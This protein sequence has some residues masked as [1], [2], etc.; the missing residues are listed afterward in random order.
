MQEI[1]GC[2]RQ[3]CLQL[4]QILRVSGTHDRIPLKLIL[5]GRTPFPM[6]AVAI[7]KRKVPSLAMA[8]RWHIYP[9]LAGSPIDPEKTIINGRCAF[10]H[11]NKNL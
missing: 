4:L 7:R 1:S 11:K 9:S 5:L 3:G 10:I 8:I 6:F 2:A